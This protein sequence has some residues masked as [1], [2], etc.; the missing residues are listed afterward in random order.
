MPTCQNCGNR[1]SL[2]DT[3]KAAFK[4]N[5]NT[6]QKCAHCG[7]TQYVSKKSRNQTGILAIIA[8]LAVVL[9]RP[10]LNQD[11]STSL[12]LAMPIV[13]VLVIAI[14]YLIKLSNTPETV[15]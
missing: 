1:W 13:G 3:F 9:I 12:L 7:E 2:K 14:I 5:G 15:R 4:F 10:L 6:G 8:F 11:V